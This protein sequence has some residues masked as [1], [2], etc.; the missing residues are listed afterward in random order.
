VRNKNTAAA[1]ATK[2]FTPFLDELCDLAQKYG[3]SG[4]SVVAF[5]TGG[6]CEL[7]A[8]GDDHTYPA[9]FKVLNDLRNCGYMRLPV[10]GNA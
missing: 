10:A 3:F 8:C 6:G 9:A 4:V 7:A 1:P 2:E 5:A